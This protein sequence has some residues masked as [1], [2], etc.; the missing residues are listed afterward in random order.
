[1]R[2]IRYAEIS[3]IRKIFYSVDGF[4]SLT[5]FPYPRSRHCLKFT[6]EMTENYGR[7]NNTR[8]QAPAVR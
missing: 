6:Q 8:S 2:F 4:L 3:I 1:M 5:L 7:T